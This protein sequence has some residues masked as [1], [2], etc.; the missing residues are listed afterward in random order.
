M[1][2]LF[3]CY[4]SFFVTFGT[5]LLLSC[6]SNIELP[7]SPDSL[8]SPSG[9]SSSS[10]GD[11]SSSSY[12]SGSSSSY[13]EDSSSSYSEDSSSSYSSG[14]SSS[15]EVSSES[16]APPQ[17][18][19][20]EFIDQ[21]DNKRYK[22]EVA[23]SGRVWMSENLNYSKGGTLGWC[24]KTGD[25]K[26][27]LGSPGENLSGCDRPYGRTYTYAIAT[28]GNPSLNKA[29]GLCPSGW[30]IPSSAE[31]TNIASKVLTGNYDPTEAMWRNRGTYG[32]YWFSNA[33]VSSKLGFVFME[34]SNIEVRTSSE[35]AMP[36]DYFSVRCIMD[37]DFEPTCGSQSLDLANELCV[38][39]TRYPKMCGSKTWNPK[40]QQCNDGVLTCLPNLPSGYFCYNDY[41][42]QEIAVDTKI[43]MTSNLNNGATNWATA[44]DLSVSCN[45]SN[46]ATTIQTQHQGICPI[47]W[48][49]PKREEITTNTFFNSSDTW[50]TATQEVGDEANY[51]YYKNSSGTATYSSKASLRPVR[52]VKN[53]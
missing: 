21:R 30:H 26:S 51:A 37:E 35:L 41:V 45:S 47:G 23:S 25:E 13:S 38:N 34:S 22:Y 24:Y 28:D 33:V 43:W 11:G 4:I 27:T 48:H 5:L 32:F 50:W 42:Y 20:D 9:N 7:P 52:C 53:N 14:S 10:D 8:S 49:I 15:S 2:K 36:N 44:M 3:P 6:T 19:G 1:K 16:Q 40:L 29:K 46:C 17:F 39:S 31:W 12:S 18:D